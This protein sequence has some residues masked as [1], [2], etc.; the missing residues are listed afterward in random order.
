MTPPI[1]LMIFAS[2]TSGIGAPQ[3]DE[4]STL[5]LKVA[6]MLLIALAI[7]V[8][9]KN[10]FGK[11]ST[12]TLVGPNP[13]RV[14]AHEEFI[15]RREFAEIKARTIAVE[16]E[17][18]AIKQS[19]HETEVRLLEAGHHREEKLMARIDTLVP[20]LAKALDRTEQRRR[21]SA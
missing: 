14:Q 18:Q 8:L 15:T 17:V 19:I 16:R 2:T 13:L 4:G 10:A 21:G 12:E 5:V 7:V 20:E 1:S 9:W 6:N 11:R 3:F